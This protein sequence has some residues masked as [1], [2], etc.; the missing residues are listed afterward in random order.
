MNQVQ[1][2]TDNTESEAAGAASTGMHAPCEDACS[3]TPV[4]C[5]T[6]EHA[7]IPGMIPAPCTC[8]TATAAPGRGLPR[9]RLTCLARKTPPF[10]LAHK[11]SIQWFGMKDMLA[12]R[13]CLLIILSISSGAMVSLTRL[14]GSTKATT[15]CEISCSFRLPIREEYDLSHLPLHQTHGDPENCIGGW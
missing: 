13:D 4:C 9:R 5:S 1:C 7:F 14:L 2:N 6:L 12:C 3:P 10:K 8:R 11:Q 15:G